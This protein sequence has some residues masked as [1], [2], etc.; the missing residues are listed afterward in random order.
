MC[1]GVPG[2]CFWYSATFRSHADMHSGNP[3]HIYITWQWKKTKTPV[4]NRKLG[5]ASINCELSLPT[6]DCRKVSV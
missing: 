1:F 5:H 4:P 3:T 6:L 2:R